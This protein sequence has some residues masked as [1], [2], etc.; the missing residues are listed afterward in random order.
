MMWFMNVP[1]CLVCSWRNTNENSFQD[2]TKLNWY[3]H[4]LHRRIYPRQYTAQQSSKTFWSLHFNLL[5]ESNNRT[6]ATISTE[7]ITKAN[8]SLQSYSRCENTRGTKVTILLVN[9][10]LLQQVQNG[11]CIC[12]L[13]CRC[14]VPHHRLHQIHLPRKVRISAFFS[15]LDYFTAFY[16]EYF[17]RTSLFLHFYHCKYTITVYMIIVL[18]L[19]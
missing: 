15:M 5:N 18:H 13:S 17:C 4:C 1:L 9:W 16:D 7:R 3:L 19:Y 10:F 12:I 2:S 11:G 6:S 8:I 14:R